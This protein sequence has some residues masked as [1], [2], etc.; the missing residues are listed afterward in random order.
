MCMDVLYVCMCECIYVHHM[1][2]HRDH[3]GGLDSFE[4][5][6]EV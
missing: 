4:P 1:Q 6:L 5:G 2:A 3:N